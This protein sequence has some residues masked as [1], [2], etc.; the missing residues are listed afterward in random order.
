MIKKIV[1]RL[2]FTAICCGLF[3]GIAL[4]FVYQLDFSSGQKPVW[5]V[6]F[7][8]SYAQQLNLDWHQT[9][10]AILDELK[11]KNLRLAAYWDQI[12]SQKN[13][14]DFSAL[15]WQIDQA[16]KR[17]AEVILVV[18]R[19]LPRWPECHDPSWLG[20]VS[21]AETEEK[22]LA[23]IKTT[24]ERYR[25][26]PAIKYWQVE[27]EPLLRWFGNCPPP[28]GELLQ[29]E[30]DLVRRLD[31][32]RPIIVSDSGELS[33][34]QSAANY[35]DILGVTLYRVVWNNYTGWFKYW[36]LPPAFYNFKVELTKR[37][38]KNLN[39]VIVTELQ[40]EPWSFNKS[41]TQLSLAEQQQSF[42]LQRF[43]A[44]LDFTTKAGF[45]TA[46][47]WGVEYW[48]WLKEQGHSEIW[49]AAKLLW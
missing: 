42:D 4:W 15:D 1:K 34:W 45:N 8:P 28:D 13:N 19:R 39:D 26:N 44:N 3:L 5:G 14:Y 21:V 18:G 48:Y 35:P 6:T 25:K 22:L 2:L 10:L 32:T 23:V 36:F 38:H 31:S 24:V 12:E 29:Q 46:Y 9:Y 11:V 27:N 43:Y 49:Q 20:Q 37:W 40:M 17:Q 41:M 7:S 30:V 16:G 47:L 33:T